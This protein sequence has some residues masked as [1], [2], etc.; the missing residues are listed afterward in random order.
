[1]RASTVVF[2]GTKVLKV[3]V[4][5]R[6]FDSFDSATALSASAS[7]KRLNPGSSP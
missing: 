3:E 6:F 5:A 4:R 1:L 2:A 7:L